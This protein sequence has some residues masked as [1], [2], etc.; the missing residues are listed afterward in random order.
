LTTIAMLLL[1]IPFVFGSVRTGLG[2]KLVLASMLGISVYL[3]DQVIANAGLLLHLNPALTALFPG[4][5]LIA[6]ANFWLRR[7]F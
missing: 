5:L 7:V 3:F 6:L 4:L 1:S 2:N